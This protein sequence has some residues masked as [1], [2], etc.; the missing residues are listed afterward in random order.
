MQTLLD[1]G[2]DTTIKNSEGK[3]AYDLTVEDGNQAIMQLFA[4]AGKAQG[5]TGTVTPDAV[6]QAVS[7]AKGLIDKF[8]GQ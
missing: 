3:T 7:F 1:A 2:T 5:D 4:N 6:D 8:T